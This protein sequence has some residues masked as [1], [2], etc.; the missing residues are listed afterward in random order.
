MALRIL[1]FQKPS[2][3]ILQLN[4]FIINVCCLKHKRR[5]EKIILSTE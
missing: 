2:K 4:L 5:S 1:H 3:L